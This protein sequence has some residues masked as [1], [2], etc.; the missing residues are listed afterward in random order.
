MVFHEEV[1]LLRSLSTKLTWILLTLWLIVLVI[2]GILAQM[3][4]E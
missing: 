4:Q 2:F 3:A 1:K